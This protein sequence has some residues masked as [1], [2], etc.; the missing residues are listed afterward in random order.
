MKKEFK[1]PFLLGIV[2]PWVFWEEYWH[3]YLMDIWWLTYSVLF[4]CRP[5]T[6]HNVIR[7]AKWGWNFCNIL[8]Y[9]GAELCREFDA[10]GR[11]FTVIKIGSLHHTRERRK[12]VIFYRTFGA[13]V[14]S[15][16]DCELVLICAAL[17]T[18]L[19]HK[20]YVFNK[21]SLL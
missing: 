7:F 19:E 5:E 20:I 18:F 8:P 17:L 2:L 10:T 16:S 6:R 11:P 3:L 4:D 21:R 1:K 13:K 9:L 12:S 15:C 14:F